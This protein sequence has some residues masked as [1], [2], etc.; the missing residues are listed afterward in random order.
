MKCVV[1]GCTKKLDVNGFPLE[2]CDYQQ[3]RCPMQRQN[4]DLPNWVAAAIL[5]IGI[6]VAVA[7]SLWTQ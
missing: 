7:V 2:Y 3:G 5:V 6:A 1:R 4:R